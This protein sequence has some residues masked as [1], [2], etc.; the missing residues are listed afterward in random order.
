MSDFTKEELN[1]IQNHGSSLDKVNEQITRFQHGF[2][3][4]NLDR[5]ATVG[6]GIL[7]ID[8]LKSSEYANIYDQAK[9]Q[10][11]IVKFVPA[12]GA[13]SRMFK[14]LFAYLE[15]ENSEPNKAAQ[16]FLDNLDNFAFANQLKVKNGSVENSHG[17]A[18]VNTLLSKEGLNYGKLPKGLL[19][20]HKYDESTRTPME[21]HLVE[22]AAYACGLG[23]NVNLH[24]TVS[25][26]HASLF[27]KLAEKIQPLL[28]NEYGVKFKV[29]YS[30]Q[31]PGTD[32]IAVDLNNQPFQEEDGS[33]L[34]RPA[35]HGA[36]L[37]NLNQIDADIVFLKNIDNVV[38]DRI[39]GG[40]TIS[41]KALAGILLEY[42]AKIFE[43]LDQLVEDDKIEEAE[44]LLTQE[45]NIELPPTYISWD[46]F[47]KID[48][49]ES[50]LNR[51][52]RVCGM[53]VNTGEPGGG[54]FYCKDQDGG[55]S[56]QI[57][58]SAQIN[59]KD[60]SQQQIVAQATHFNPVD[61]VCGLKDMNGQKFDL[62]LHIDSDTGLISNKS[63]N[64]RE[65]KAQELPG[66]WNGSMADW[67]TIFVEVPAIT[68]NPVKTVLDLLRPEHQ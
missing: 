5:A 52:I 13:A 2:P 41:K 48:Y 12:S 3:F 67:N 10:L 66:L 42:Q 4:I 35:G 17:K 56:L 45:L 20:F 19:Q 54:P 6:D 21:E 60:D 32:T 1:Q 47:V 26:E 37:Q 18:I 53:V 39:K 57:V 46:P 59:S 14:D 31:A 24:F 40:G 44:L 15:S 63:K 28:E 9:T 65:L 61:V 16:T 34:F 50:K 38:P 27:T 22:G 30:Q 64:G 33:I 58:E 29:S 11:D 7:R 36:L 68:F 23:N 49:L 55:S 43:A 25:P 8:E 62:S 51:P